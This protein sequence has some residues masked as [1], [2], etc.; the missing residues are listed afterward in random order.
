MKPKTNPKPRR[1]YYR[2]EPPA[3]PAPA[4]VPAPSPPPAPTVEAAAP[5][6]KKGRKVGVRWVDGSG[7]Y[8]IVEIIDAKGT[9]PY[10]LSSLGKGV[11]LFRKLEVGRETTYVVTA[12]K[13]PSCNCIGFTTHGHCRHVEAL[14]SLKAGGK[15]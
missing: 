10:L 6:P 8:A 3:P 11:H 5:A 2:G 4:P 13:T 12:W 9:T 7:S 15:L 1:V 14:V